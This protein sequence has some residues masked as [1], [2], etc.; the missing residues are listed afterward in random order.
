VP[1]VSFDNTGADPEGRW[2]LSTVITGNVF[3][4][5][6]YNRPYPARRITVACCASA[7]TERRK[8]HHCTCRDADR[9]PHAGKSLI[10]S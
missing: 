5:D 3:L 10:S 6:L 2:L 7:T 9:Y 4:W 1:F 8:P